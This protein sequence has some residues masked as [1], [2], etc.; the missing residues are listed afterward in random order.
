ML[1][2]DEFWGVAIDGKVLHESTYTDPDI[3]TEAPVLY[4]DKRAAHNQASF[5]DG[6]VSVVKMKVSIVI[7]KKLPKND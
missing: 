3:N 2:K 6:D 4:K 5:N 1:K 7:N